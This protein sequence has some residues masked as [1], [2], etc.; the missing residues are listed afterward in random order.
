MK[1]LLFFLLIFVS[2]N[3][4]DVEV[5]HWNCK[6]KF[7]KGTSF[8]L[9]DRT[10]NPLERLTFEHDTVIDGTV[11]YN[12]QDDRYSFSIKH[13]G[14]QFIY[15]DIFFDDM[16]VVFENDSLSWMTSE[17]AQC[18][19]YFEKL[20][21]DIIPGENYVIKCDGSKNIYTFTLSLY[22]YSICINANMYIE[23]NKV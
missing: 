20:D 12:P 14:K 21:C 5:E 22:E 7:E 1:Y 6:F 4:E 15:N 18:N 16:I 17:S 23:I 3:V 13:I 9:C 2:C 19:F 10:Y 11:L 8:T